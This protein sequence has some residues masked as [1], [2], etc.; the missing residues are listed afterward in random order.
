MKTYKSL[1]TPVLAA[2]VAAGAWAMPPIPGFIKA[3]QPDGTSVELSLRGD[4]YF[5]WAISP[6]GYTLIRDDAGYW[7]VAMPP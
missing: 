3:S 5:S 6:D 2:L 4:E 7:T 1:L